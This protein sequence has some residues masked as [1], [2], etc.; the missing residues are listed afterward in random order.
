[1]ALDEQQRLDRAER[2]RQLREESPYTQ[3]A[4][5]DL[6]LAVPWTIVAVAVLTAV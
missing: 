2:I 3:A 6:L 4:L 5:A 1:M